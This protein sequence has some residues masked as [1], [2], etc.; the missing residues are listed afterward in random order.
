MLEDMVNRYSK[1]VSLPEPHAN[2]G[3]HS[4][5]NLCCITV[6]I[7]PLS[8]ESTAKASVI[9]MYVLYDK[10]NNIMQH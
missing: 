3:I 7:Q 9:H 6:P 1:G 4:Q 2:P 10:L 5:C 8:A